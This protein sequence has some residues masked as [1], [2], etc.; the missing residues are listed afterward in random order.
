MSDIESGVQMQGTQFNALWVTEGADGSF[1]RSIVSRSVGDLPPGDLLVRV[2]YSSLNYKDALSAT[3]V[4]G[5]TRS[6]PHT[7]GI[8]AAGVVA[9]S[10]AAGF[11]PGDEV[12]ATGYDLGMNTSGGF[13][14]YVRI[15]AGWAVKRPIA[16]SLRESMVYG[17]AGFTAAMAVE[18]LVA[19]GIL[20]GDGD[21]LVTGATGGVGCI[22]VAIL[23]KLGYRVTAATGKPASA[24]FLK[25]LGADS[26]ISRE[27]VIDERRRALQSVRWAGTIDT[28]GGEFLASAISATAQWGAVA[29]T[30][31]AASPMLETT[32][33]PFIL[34]GVT[35]YGV[36]SEKLPI[37]E[38]ARLWELL[39]RDWKPEAL[40]ALARKVAL[41]GLSAEID[42]ILHGGQTGRVLVNLR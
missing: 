29:S 37:S 13:G 15:P 19:H 35:L 3:G 5:V 12:I 8:D 36:N 25:G 42:V 23:A 27:G 34:R 28:V 10:D 11:S 33:Y 40:E 39:G 2:H 17:T 7:P 21:V 30:G 6:Y 26:V 18:K 22:A 20:P 1:S 16:L 14:Q 24:D 4:K 32:V 9:E 38:R 31:N 41:S